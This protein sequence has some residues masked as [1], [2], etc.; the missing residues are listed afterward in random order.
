MAAMRRRAA[1][2]AGATTVIVGALTAPAFAISVA[3]HH[4]AKKGAPD[5]AGSSA[6]L[7]WAGGVILAVAV[8]VGL[9][10]FNERIRDRARHIFGAGGRSVREL[11]SS[12]TGR[13]DGA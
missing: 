3:L 9:V 11:Q 1:L 10:V 2:L 8:V 13:P 6:D 12:P 7:I 4:P 5:S